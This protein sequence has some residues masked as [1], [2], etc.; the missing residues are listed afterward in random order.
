MPINEL[1]GHRYPVR[2]VKFS[3]HD[4]NVLASASYDMMTIIWNTADMT[5][6]VLHMHSAH[7]EFVVGLDFSMHVPK[8]I[9]TSSWDGK[10]LVWPWDQP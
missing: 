1:Q 8:L 7:T 6:P 2:R 5:T 9:A 4:A 3:P 10:C